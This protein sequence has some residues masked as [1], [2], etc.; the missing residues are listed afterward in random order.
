MLYY[1]HDIKGRQNSMLDMVNN[2]NILY[3]D[4]FGSKMAPGV[5]LWFCNLGTWVLAEK[6][7]R[8]KT[9]TK[10]EFIQKVTEVDVTCRS[11]S[12]GLRK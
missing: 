9:Q 7:F 11:K 5:R 10:T 1:I 4:I 8:T 12:N 2:E 3:F 6:E